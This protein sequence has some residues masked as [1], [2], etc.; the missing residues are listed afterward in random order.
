MVQEHPHIWLRRR[1]HADEAGRCF[2]VDASV[3]EET[4]EGDG[5]RAAPQHRPRASPVAAREH[6]L[7]ASPAV[8]VVQRRVRRGE[9]RRD[10][11]LRVHLGDPQ[12]RF[13][14]LHDLS[15]IALRRRARPR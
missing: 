14:Q 15:V 6:R 4:F 7:D 12:A 2:D 5:E 8:N 13:G 9:E 1:T 10:G 11:R 3:L